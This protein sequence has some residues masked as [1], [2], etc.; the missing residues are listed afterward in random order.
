MLLSFFSFLVVESTEGRDEKENL[1]KEG[2]AG[3]E[4]GAGRS[5]A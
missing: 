2:G 4:V 5:C 3:E 1:A